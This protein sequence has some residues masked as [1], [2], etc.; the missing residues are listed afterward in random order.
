MS[1]SDRRRSVRRTPGEMI[2]EIKGHK[3]LGA[4]RGMPAVDTDVLVPC[5]MAVGR[6]G[7]EREEIQAIDVNPLIIR[8]SKPVAVDALVILKEK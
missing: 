4:I 3:I 2:G 8:G 6:I 5:L 7:L 1:R